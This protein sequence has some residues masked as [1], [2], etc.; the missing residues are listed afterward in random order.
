MSNSDN[1]RRDNQ[2]KVDYSL[3]PIDSLE[4]E[5]KVWMAGEKK[6]GRDN[7][8]KLWGDKTV[9]VV[10]ASALRHLF[11]IMEGE[12]ID[13]ETGLLHAAH[14]R[15]NMAM[16]IRYAKVNEQ[17]QKATI[18]PNMTKL[19]DDLLNAMDS[20]TGNGSYYSQSDGR[21]ITHIGDDILTTTGDGCL[22]LR[23]KKGAKTGD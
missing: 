21:V 16:L 1:A 3:L 20:L 9:D 8:S 13:P 15:C 4:E 18:T 2:G 10:C 17:I 14:V 5:T 11:A 6:Y 22:L 23:G 7:W 19:K 12:D